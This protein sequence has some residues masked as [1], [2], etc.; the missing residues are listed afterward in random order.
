MGRPPIGKRAMTDAERQRARRERLR[1]AAS[2]PPVNAKPTAAPSDELVAARK[3]IERAQAEIER[4]R[5]ENA[6][7][8]KAQPGMNAKGMNFC[9]SKRAAS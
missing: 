8:K 6:T 2:G 5:T 9:D 7:L 4:L 3:E 1:K